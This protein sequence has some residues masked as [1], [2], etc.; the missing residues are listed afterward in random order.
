[1][2]FL[3]SHTHDCSRMT[4]SPTPTETFSRRNS[5]FGR[6]WRQGTAL[7]SNSL[8]QSP[9]DMPAER[10]I[11]S[12]LPSASNGGRVSDR[13]QQYGLVRQSLALRTEFGALCQEVSAQTQEAVARVYTT[14]TPWLIRSEPLVR[15]F[16]CWNRQVRLCRGRTALGDN[17]TEARPEWP[18]SSSV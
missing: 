18:A 16:D 6:S 4:A 1:M 5:L 9:M 3:A 14:A 7:G 12:A 17:Q 2:G 8:P 11:T 13:Q 10:L 15:A